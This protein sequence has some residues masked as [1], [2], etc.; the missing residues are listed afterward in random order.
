MSRNLDSARAFLHAAIG[1]D[2][3]TCRQLIAAGYT[4]RDRT[5]ENLVESPEQLQRTSE[6]Y[7]AAWSDK[8]LE[9]ERIVETADGT[10]YDDLSRMVQ[11]GAIQL[12]DHD[13]VPPRSPSMGRGALEPSRSRG[14]A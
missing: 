5:R 2:R 11:I 10:V 14:R 13:R 7:R 12:P 8:A 3:E 4:Y 1:D 6:E 9:I